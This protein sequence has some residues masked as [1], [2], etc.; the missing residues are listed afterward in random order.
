MSIT[1][2][3]CRV[4][5]YSV[6]VC[7][8]TAGHGKDG[9]APTSPVARSAIGV[10]ELPPVLAGL[11]G[12]GRQRAHHALSIATDA[13]KPFLRSLGLDATDC[14]L[15]LRLPSRLTP[16]RESSAGLRLDVQAQAGLGCRF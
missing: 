4:L 12:A 3:H 11:P 1:P 10:I 14:T 2:V 6:L 16:S 5:L 13:P 8:S 7:A 9:E 15:R